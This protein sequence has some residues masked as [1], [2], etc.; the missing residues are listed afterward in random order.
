VCRG[1]N[2]IVSVHHQR[3][4]YCILFSRMTQIARKAKYTLSC[5]R[6]RRCISIRGRNG[7]RSGDSLNCMPFLVRNRREPGVC[8]S[9]D[10]LSPESSN[11][12][13]GEPFSSPRSRIKRRQVI[14]LN[15]SLDPVLNSSKSM[16]QRKRRFLRPSPP[17]LADVSPLTGDD[18]QE[19]YNVVYKI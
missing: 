6:K 12:S 7:A 5:R 16:S 10:G 2:D 8:A 11:S 15:I 4:G 18:C 9:D 17:I 19:T 14:L 13:Q 1:G 3:F